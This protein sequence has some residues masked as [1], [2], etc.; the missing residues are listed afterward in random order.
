ME[1]LGVT[2]ARGDAGRVPR[3]LAGA[4]GAL[5]RGLGARAHP[6]PQTLLG[7]CCTARALPGERPSAAGHA[8]PLG[9]GCGDALA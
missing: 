7:A 3:S 8:A 9:V 1:R 5:Q 6:D 2:R 4:V